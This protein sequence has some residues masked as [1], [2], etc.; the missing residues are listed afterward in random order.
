[1]LVVF[2]IF[3]LLVELKSRL[4]VDHENFCQGLILGSLLVNPYE[5]LVAS[6][7]FDIY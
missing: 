1:M 2:G 4:Q 5:G 6:P 3:S 7:L